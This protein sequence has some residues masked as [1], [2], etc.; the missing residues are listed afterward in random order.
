MQSPI[1]YEKVTEEIKGLSFKDVEH[2]G[3]GERTLREIKQKIRLGKPLNWKHGTV[4]KLAEHL[5]N[6]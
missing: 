5:R 2:T 3:I 1:D 4:K 6:C